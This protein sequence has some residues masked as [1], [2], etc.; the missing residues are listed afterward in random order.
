MK[1]VHLPAC[2]A[3]VLFA[4]HPARAETY[5]GSTFLSLARQSV[6]VMRSHQYL[7]R[8]RLVSDSNPWHFQ[9]TTRTAPADFV[10]SDGTTVSGGLTRLLVGFGGGIG[11]PSDGFSLAFGLHI[12]GAY[13]TEAI[14]LSQHKTVQAASQQGMLYATAAT[15]WF[16]LTGGAIFYGVEGVDSNGMFRRAGDEQ[17]FFR[18]G[19]PAEASEVGA[20]QDR[21]QTATMLTLRERHALSVGAVISRVKERTPDG[22][23]DSRNALAALR[24]MIAPEALLPE[25]G[26]FHVGLD[27][28]AGEIDYYSERTEEN[29]RA[30]EQGLPLPPTPSEALYEIPLGVD[31]LLGA[32]I[33]LRVVGQV[34][35]TVKPRLAEAGMVRDEGSKNVSFVYGGRFIAFARNDNIEPSADAFA[36]IRFL[37]RQASSTLSYSYNSPDSATFFPVPDAHVYGFQVVY[38][39]LEAARPLVPIVT[40]A[41][42]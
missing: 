29:R 36:G 25:L 4:A 24:S 30:I 2:A 28:V 42:E 35:P 38:G 15:P 32:G 14:P 16:V 22:A 9:W 7:D 19:T 3:V 12:D 41:K 40:R 1:A 5:D 10:L 11:K 13:T 37:G 27:R 8:F 31:D 39:P 21:R 17:Q 26:L 6:D 33:R 34:A 20:S 18:P 23:L